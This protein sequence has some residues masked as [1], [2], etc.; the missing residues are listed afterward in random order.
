L[1]DAKLLFRLVAASLAFPFC[2]HAQTGRIYTSDDYTRAANL[3]QA[4]TISLV[5]HA[6]TCASFIG[7]HRFWYI[8]TDH[9]MPTLMVADA[10]NRT[11]FAAYDHLRMAAALQAAGLDEKD[12]KRILPDVGPLRGWQ[13]YGGHDVTLPGFCL[14]RHRGERQPRE[15]EL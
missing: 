4:S 10:I 1:I 13:R 3:L 11:K 2:S 15:P 6:V 8:D 14:G 12:P 9:G 5:D 7:N